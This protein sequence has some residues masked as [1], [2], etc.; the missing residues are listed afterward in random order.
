MK[1]VYAYDTHSKEYRVWCSIKNRCFPSS[2]VS[3]KEESLGMQEEWIGCFQTFLNDVGNRPSNIHKLIR[4]DSNKGFYKDNVCWS[5]EQNK[6]RNYR[7]FLTYN[8]ITLPLK[9][10]CDKY[11]INYGTALRRKKSGWSDEAIIE[12]PADPTNKHKKHYK[13]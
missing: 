3:T 9:E 6:Q 4:I 2:N 8:D 13:Y 7:Y 10:W 1:Q 12:T 11:N 5:L